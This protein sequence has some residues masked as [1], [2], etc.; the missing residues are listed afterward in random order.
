MAEAS[1]NRHAIPLEEIIGGLSA[2]DN[3]CDLAQRFH[4]LPDPREEAHLRRDWYG[5]GEP[6]GL[7]RWWPQHK[8]EE[9]VRLAYIR[10]FRL[11]LD[12]DLPM[13]A[14]W[15]TGHDD[16]VV[17]VLPSKFQVTMM[18]ITP[19][20]PEEGNRAFGD[21]LIAIYE[22]EGQVGADEGMLK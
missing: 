14:Y 8:V 17:S 6:G 16:F 19:H 18:L 4:L 10:A 1:E 15:L 5:E 9:I 3:L 11:V 22:R 20:P 12:L 21:G 2:G 13:V 7:S